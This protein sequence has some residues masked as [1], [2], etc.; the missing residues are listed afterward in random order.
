MR[1]LLIDIETS[2]CL[3]HVWDLWNQ[4]IGLSQLIESTEMLCFSARWLGAEGTG[5]W[6]VHNGK[7]AMLQAAHELLDQADV[8]IHYNGR[9]FDVPHLNRELLPAGYKPPSPFRQIDLYLVIKKQFRFPSNKLAYVSKALGLRGKIQHEGHELWV[10]CMAGDEDA[11]RCMEE[12]N[13][14]D[15]HLLEELYEYLQPWIPRHPSH[16]SFTGEDVCP[17][18]GSANL[19]RQGYAYTQVSR[20]QRYRCGDCGKW[21]RSNRR[22]QATGITEVAA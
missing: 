10:K 22:D 14:Q 2:P 13:I 6:S 4:N 1:V 18:C 3:A 16:G 15:V 7:G 8:V 12:Y 19:I 9:S 20:F 21:S 5:F 17:A 11:W